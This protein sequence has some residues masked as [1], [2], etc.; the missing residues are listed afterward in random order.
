MKLQTKIHLNKELNQIDYNSHLFFLGSCFSELIGGKFEHFKFQSSQNP[1]GIFFHP[2]AIEN[3]IE[4]AINKLVYSEK[5]I[6]F[7]NERWHCFDAHSDLS[8]VTKEQLL[9][10]LNAGLEATSNQIKKAS[11][12]VIT[13]GTSWVYR[14]AEIDKIVSNC[15]KLPQKTFEKEILSTEIVS[16]C[17]NSC[18]R[19]IQTINKD[20]QVIFTVS[21]VRHLKDGFVENQRSKAHLIAAIHQVIHQD[22][23]SYFP[24]YEIMMDELRDYRFYKTDMIHPNELAV[25]YIWERFKNTWISDTE[26][27]IMDKVEAVQRDLKHRPFNPNSEQHKKFQKTLEKKITYLQETYSFMLF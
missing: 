5:D 4:R 17:I 16:N 11:H 19:K 14:K 1:F 15:H 6:F 22:N 10:K 3:L 21:P 24:S 26:Y 18:I 20:V 2:L 23:V 27:P 9:Q 8:D 7:Y 25:D 12:I 13:L